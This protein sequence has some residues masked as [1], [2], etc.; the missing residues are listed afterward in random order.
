MLPVKHIE[1]EPTQISH[2]HVSSLYAPILCAFNAPTIYLL[3]QHSYHQTFNFAPFLL[4]ML[5]YL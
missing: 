2:L 3:K 4:G 5:P 1:L